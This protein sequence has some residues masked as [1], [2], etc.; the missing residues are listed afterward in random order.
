[1]KLAD[2]ARERARA[3]PRSRPNAEIAEIA[4]GIRGTLERLGKAIGTH[5]ERAA[6]RI[7]AVVRAAERLPTDAHAIVVG[8]DRTT[9]P[10]EEL[11]PPGTRPTTRRKRRT[12]PYVRTPPAPADVGPN[13]RSGGGTSTSVD[14]TQRSTPTT[15]RSI[16]SSRWVAQRM[17]T[18][19]VDTAAIE[20]HFTYLT[21]HQHRMR[22]ATLRAHGL[23]CGSGATEGAC[24][25]V[26]TMRAKGSGQRWHEDGVT[27]ALTLRAIYL[28]GRLS[29]MWPHVATDYSAEIQ[30]AA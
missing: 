24:K 21:N 25:S 23:P 18:P 2:Q 29:T 8:L 15:G 19:E 22:Y 11:R 6:P 13:L 17:T 5:T 3:P 26:V 14:G 7:E 12:A 9:V 27:A 10:M 1:M 20:P 16:A 30:A 28:S 4:E